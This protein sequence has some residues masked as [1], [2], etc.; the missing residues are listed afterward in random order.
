MVMIYESND[1]RTGQED[2][3]ARGGVKLV[4]IPKQ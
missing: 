4:A 2:R 3:G 1:Q